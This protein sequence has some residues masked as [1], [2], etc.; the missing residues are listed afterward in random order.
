MPLDL[1][2]LDERDRGEHVREVRLVARDDDVVER[3]VA[4]A[5]EP[6]VL[7]RLRD[8]RV[9][10]RDQAALAGGDVLRRVE[11]EAGRLGDR[12]DLAAAVLALGGVRGVL[13]ERDAEGE[14]RVEVGGLAGEVDGEDRLRP[15]GDE[16]GDAVGVDV[17]VGVAHVREDRRRAGVDD[18][19]RGRGPR[20]GRRDHLV[21]RAR[22]RPRAARGAARPSRTRPRARARPGRTRRSAA[23][24]RPRAARSSAS[25]SAGSRRRPRSP[26]RRS[27]A[28]GTRAWSRFCQTRLFAPTLKRMSRA[29]SSA[30]SSA[31]SR[32]SPIA[33]TAPAR[34]AP[35]RNGPKT[36]PGSR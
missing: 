29:A 35:R 30:R 33:S 27:P 5:H 32:V 14:E 36:W 1:V 28:A 8:L 31:S 12:A 7:D 25:P 22:R 18:H 13:D 6:Q 3:A 21:A 2:E 23:R 26:R 24:A 9:V 11:R 10:R 16:L 34:S 17:Q 4:A 20:D 19:V 15:V